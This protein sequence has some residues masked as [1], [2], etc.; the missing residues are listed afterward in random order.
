M[1]P[2]TADEVHEPFAAGVIRER[3]AIATPRGE[4]AGELAYPA[5]G[6]PRFAAL[7]A[8][9][10]PY[11]GGTMRHAL[12]GAIGDELATRGGVSLRFDYGDLSGIDVAA[13]M[14]RFWETGHAPED[15]QRLDA[16]AD[17][18]SFLIHCAPPAARRLVMVGYSF[19]C[20]VA[21]RLWLDRR[22]PRHAVTE[23]VLI[24]PTM[25]R[26]EFVW[27]DATTGEVPRMLVIHSADD[28]ATPLTAVKNWVDS[29]NRAH[30]DRQSPNGRAAEVDFSASTSVAV[31]LAEMPAGNHFFRGSETDIAA[32]AGDFAARACTAGGGPEA[33][34]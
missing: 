4:F 27:P 8:G 34:T 10:H 21:W 12:I 28:F 25:T 18:A 6:A 32:I 20:H 22:V 1:R 14:A 5:R 26:H 19:G 31:S 13:S 3:V 23:V 24:S 11:M 2:A 30:A 17:A 7:L 15:A 33:A 29:A 16:A 9:P